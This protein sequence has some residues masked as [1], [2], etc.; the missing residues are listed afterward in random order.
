MLSSVKPQRRPN[1]K[2]RALLSLGML[3]GIA[4]VGTM[5]AWTD[6]A[7]V[8]SGSFETGTLDLKVGEKTAGEL[9]GQG[10]SWQHTSLGLS[11]MA[12]GESV[13]QMLT[14]GNGGSIPL[15]YNGSVKAGQALA[16]PNGLLVS[17]IQN[18]TGATNTGTQAGGN[19]QGSCTGG[20]A[21][22]VANTSVGAAP[23]TI[24]GG[25]MS[26]A[27]GATQAYCVV[28]KLSADAPNTMQ[29]ESTTVTI[30][31]NAEQ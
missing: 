6:S 1:G 18:A 7:T 2:V 26:L 11:D 15:S 16:G 19:R 12:P 23:S 9:G 5:A 25:D 13:A 4:Q 20:S 10:G 14:V 30:D 29:A 21:T 27:P 31:F 17:V 22:A 8:R 24:H 3:L 28:V